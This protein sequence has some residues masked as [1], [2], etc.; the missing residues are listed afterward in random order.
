MQVWRDLCQF[1][2]TVWSGAWGLMQGKKKDSI[3][4]HTSSLSTSG[5]IYPIRS[6]WK[7][8]EGKFNPIKFWCLYLN[9][10]LK[11]QTY[12]TKTPSPLLIILLSLWLTGQLHELHHGSLTKGNSLL[13][14]GEGTL[15]SPCQLGHGVTLN[16]CKGTI[17]VPF[18]VDNGKWNSVIHQRA[19]ELYTS[20]L[21][22]HR[23]KEMS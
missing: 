13:V 15:N 3:P 10:S 23:V 4:V 7:A 21:A 2:L 1:Q 8:V 9:S 12:K 11:L 20:K 5:F 16:F 22:D 19:I 17:Y 14:I 6:S 18:G